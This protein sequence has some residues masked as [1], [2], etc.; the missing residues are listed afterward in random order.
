MKP[1]SGITSQHAY[2]AASILALVL[3][4]LLISITRSGTARLDRTNRTLRERDTTLAT[5]QTRVRQ[6]PKLEMRH[7]ELAKTLAVLEPAVSSGAYVPTLLRQMEGLA[8]DTGNRMMGLKPEPVLK[9]AVAARPSEAGEEVP[10]A[11]KQQTKAAPARYEQLPIQLNL[12]SN[13]QTLLA[14]L[15]RLSTFPKMIAVNEMSLSP[16]AQSGPQAQHSIHTFT[17]KLDLVALIQRQE[18]K[19][20]KSGAKS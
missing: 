11:D 15:H 18:S 3:L 7:Q 4:A 12:E 17:G 14:L 20:W 16:A 6:L 5:L 10:A 8:K 9:V 1:R 13:Y 19:K 2:A